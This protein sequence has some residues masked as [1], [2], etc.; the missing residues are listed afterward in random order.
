MTN[1]SLL[2]PYFTALGLSEGRGDDCALHPVAVFLLHDIIYQ[3]FNESIADAPLKHQ[4]AKLLRAWKKTNEEHF[5]KIFHYL[6]DESRDYL[7]ELMDDLSD[8]IANDLVILRS[9]IMDGLS[10]VDFKKQLLLGHIQLCN[11]L[12]QLS[13]FLWGFCFNRGKHTH[14]YNKAVRYYTATLT[15]L[16]WTNDH[17]EEH[18]VKEGAADKL[19]KLVESLFMKIL[20]WIND[21][22][23]EAAENN[24]TTQDRE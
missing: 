5:K 12:A 4:S 21:R 2:Q 8:H 14:P 3:T 1:L 9:N 11:L 18:L 15:A 24:G 10:A 23:N 22:S 16:I 13:D 6:N 17:K 19:S 20:R 7:I